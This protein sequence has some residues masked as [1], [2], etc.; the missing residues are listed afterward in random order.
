MLSLFLL[1][2]TE[3]VTK[4]RNSLAPKTKL[5]I[6]L[7]VFRRNGCVT[8][9]LIVWTV[10]MKIR[11]PSTVPNSRVVRPISLAVATDAVLIR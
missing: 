10:R 7:S 2:T 3:N 6:A 11:Q 9:I 5:G 8:A 4:K 1:Q